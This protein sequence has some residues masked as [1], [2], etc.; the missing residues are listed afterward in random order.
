MRI[1]GRLVFAVLVA[2]ASEAGAQG[3]PARAVRIIVG[4]APGGGTDTLARVIGPHLSNMWKQPV[5]IDNRPGADG[6]IAAGIIA[7]A[8]ADGY[9]LAMVSNAHTITPNQYKLPYDPIKS[10]APVTEVAFVPDILLV[11][12]SLPIHSLAELIS[13]AKANPGKL[14]YGSS[15]TGTSPYL[16]MKLLERMAGI[17]LV[18]VPYKGSAPATTALLGGEVQ[19]MFGAVS[20]TIEQVRGGRLRAIAISSAAPSPAAPEVMPVG[21]D[22]PGF[23]SSVWYGLLAPAGTPPEVV[24]K[25]SDDIRTVLA[26]PEVKERVAGLGFTVVADP[27]AHFTATIASDIKRWAE[28]IGPKAP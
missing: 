10:F 22:L 20:T 5:V 7:Q 26:L 3:F 14:N 24:T 9:T 25:I 27:P 19:L 18:H 12:P 28:L 13:Y 8:P 11:N 1:W 15:G 6:S 2:F 21:K 4:F 17:Q 16:E 23:E